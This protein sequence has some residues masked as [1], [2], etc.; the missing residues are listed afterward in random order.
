MVNESK[1]YWNIFYKN[2]QLS[3]LPELQEES[4]FAHFTLDFLHKNALE[5]SGLCLIDWGSGNGRD[6]CF[7][8]GK[9]RNVLAI[10]QSKLALNLIKSRKLTNL[11]CVNY[12]IGKRIYFL[13]YFRLLL[14]INAARSSERPSIHYARFFLHSLAAPTFGA[15][16]ILL[17]KLVRRDDLV[18]LEFRTLV[19]ESS[20]NVFQH[21]RWYRSDSQVI[22]TF[23]RKG[24]RLL[25]HEQGFNLAL[26]R[27]ENPKITRI[28]LTK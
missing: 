10:D 28:V 3:S 9:F 16:S 11:Y 26:F 24:F 1:S 12:K 4:N 5:T 15:Y 13:T 14:K 18:F 7:F 21:K 19:D 2:I 27:T 8:A 17:S 23:L 20:E 25:H 6:S 22:Q